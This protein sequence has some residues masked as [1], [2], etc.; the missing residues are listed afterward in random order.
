M[1]NEASTPSPTR[2]SAVTD[3]KMFNDEFTPEQLAQARATATK[4]GFTLWGL[5]R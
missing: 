4:H 2:P 5:D 3:A 1:T